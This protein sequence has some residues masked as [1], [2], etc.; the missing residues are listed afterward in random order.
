MVK[1]AKNVKYYEGIGR[2][3]EAVA[4]VRLYIV[5]KDKTA[6]VGKT[7]IK[8]GEAYI[9][10]KILN[11]TAIPHYQKDFMFSP[12]SATGNDG[13]FAI[14]ILTSG[15]GPN[16]QIEAVVHGVARALDLVDR[17]EYRPILKN[18]GLLTRDPRTR[19]RR[20]VGTGGKARRVKQSPK[21]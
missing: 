16:S 9:N 17:A 19:E 12:L 5:G 1:K 18:L 3:K 20:K 6:E 14:S 13:R 4:R 7:K 2:R 21:R 8:A 15:G 11:E 10:G